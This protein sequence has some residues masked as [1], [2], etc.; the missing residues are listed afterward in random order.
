MHPGV[1]FVG[2]VLGKVWDL[3]VAEDGE[4]LEQWEPEGLPLRR[5]SF[6]GAE[7]TL[8]IKGHSDDG[9]DLQ[10]AMKQI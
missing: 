10:D 3:A 8:Q 1:V 4:D 7:A 5:Q 6:E 2:R 9:G